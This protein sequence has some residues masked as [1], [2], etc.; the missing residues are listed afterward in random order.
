MMVS[1]LLRPYD[2]AWA[3]SNWILVRLWKGC[4]FAF[5]YR[6]V[7]STAK[8]RN[9]GLSGL[10]TTSPRRNSL[11]P[12]SVI[13]I[14]HSEAPHLVEKKMSLLKPRV[15]PVLP[16]H[17]PPCPSVFYQVSSNFEIPATNAEYNSYRTSPKAHFLRRILSRNIWRSIQRTHLRSLNLFS[18][19]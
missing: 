15:T 3:Q 13:L 14:F 12:E 2:R 7:L 1:A 8:F 9:S 4:G 6:S 11:N 17:P 10:E 5:R 18:L 19:N 16:P